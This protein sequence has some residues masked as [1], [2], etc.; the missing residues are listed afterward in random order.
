M[1]FPCGITSVPPD[2]VE[3][4]LFHRTCETSFFEFFSRHLSLE[5]VL[6]SDNQK[7]HP[8][9]SCQRSSNSDAHTG[10]INGPTLCIQ[11]IFTSNSTAVLEIASSHRIYSHLEGQDC[12]GSSRPMLASSEA[13]RLRR[14]QIYPAL[15]ITTS[16]AQSSVKLPYFFAHDLSSDETFLKRRRS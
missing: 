15:D 6:A 5:N 8:Y 11:R 2:E 7:L 13:R 16:V 3:L 12:F 14:N 9:W 4:M 1:Q 10:Y